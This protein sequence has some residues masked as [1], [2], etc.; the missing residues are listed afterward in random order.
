[1]THKIMSSFAP[2]PLFKLIEGLEMSLIKFVQC[3]GHTENDY[4]DSYITAGLK[5][6]CLVGGANFHYTL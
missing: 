1:M 3:T 6:S 5:T 2:R 4:T